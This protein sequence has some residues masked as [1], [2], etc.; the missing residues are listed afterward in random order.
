MQCRN[1]KRISAAAYFSG[2]VEMVAQ[3]IFRALAFGGMALVGSQA[4]AEQ[5]S[6]RF[7]RWDANKDGRVTRE[8]MSAWFKDSFDEIDTNKDGVIT[9]DEEQKFRPT[10]PQG[11][12]NAQIPNTVRSVPDLP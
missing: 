2:R 9:P 12:P 6:A 10:N 3:S 11:G 4:V 7:G 5:T 8:E 1:C